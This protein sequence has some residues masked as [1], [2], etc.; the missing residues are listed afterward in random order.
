MHL[1][2]TKPKNVKKTI[3]YPF[4]SNSSSEKENGQKQKE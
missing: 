4:L 3:R 2:I 1:K